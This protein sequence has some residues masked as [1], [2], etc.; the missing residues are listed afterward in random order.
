MPVSKGRAGVMGV[1]EGGGVGYSFGGIKVT[2][3]FGKALKLKLL[4]MFVL[5]I[6]SR[7]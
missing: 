3:S 7:Y 4:T 2:F 5:K 1:G 6:C